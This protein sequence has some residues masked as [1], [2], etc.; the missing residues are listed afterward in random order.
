MRGGNLGSRLYDGRISRLATEELA[1]VRRGDW[2]AAR[3]AA[4]EKAALKEHVQ[5]TEAGKVRP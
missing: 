2:A 4:V 5:R 1:A 3:R